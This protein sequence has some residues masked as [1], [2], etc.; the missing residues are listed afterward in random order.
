VKVLMTGG[1]RKARRVALQ[2]LFEIELT[3]HSVETTLEWLLQENPL[4]EETVPFARKLIQGVLEHQRKLD[5]VIQRFAPA[6]P[7]EQIAA[8]DRNI[9]RI[10][11][12]E[13]LF[14]R[15]VPYKVAI[16][17]A[18]E[19]AK[20]FGAENSARFVNGVL[21]S[22]CRQLGEYIEQKP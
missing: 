12:Y 2:A 21:G 10:A 6:W 22:L 17:E 4:P 16:D 7:V 13:I 14:Q 1:R 18:V 20:T 8:V 5:A 9:L 15:E 3:G 11:L 19:L